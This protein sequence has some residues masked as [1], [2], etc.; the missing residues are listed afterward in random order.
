V[1]SHIRR[2][3]RG[4]LELANTQPFARHMGGRAH[5]FAHNGFVADPPP[6]PPQVRT[7][8]EPV[9]DTDS[10]RIFCLLLAALEPVWRA[11]GVPPLEDRLEVV[12]TFAE[13]MRARG[14]ANFLYCDGETLFAHAHRKTLPGDAISDEP[15]LHLLERQAGCEEDTAV[16]LE[17]VRGEG[18]CECQ[19]LVASVP[20]NQQAWSPLASGELACFEGGRRVR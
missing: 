16:P 13:E 14:A 7:W 11:G 20:L 17:G 9:G 12:A 5:V 19:V 2:A 15:G 3:N 18:E 4:G 10:E 8:L 1:I 6:L